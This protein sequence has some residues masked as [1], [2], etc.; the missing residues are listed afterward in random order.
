[1]TKTKA[2][3]AHRLETHTLGDLQARVWPE[4]P[5][6]SDLEALAGS[7]NRFGYVEPLTIDDT[8][9][10]VIAGHGVL[11]ALLIRQE[12]GLTMPRRVTEQ[13]DD[14]A[15]SVVH[16]SLDEGEAKPYTLAA[17]RT[18]EL[19][20][21]DNEELAK[22]LQLIAEQSELGL[23]GLGW[24]P[25]EVEALLAGLFGELPAS[26]NEIPDPLAPEA[27]TAKT[28]TCPHCGETFT[29]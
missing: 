27:A 15:V 9:G 11:A 24:Q 4:Y 20:T 25:V 5:R 18:S 2:L 10:Q 3:P 29:A 28:F 26:F 7:V 23:E 19:G 13:G 21:W 16:V 6:R 1:M 12:D 22:Q 14:W 17:A 8:S